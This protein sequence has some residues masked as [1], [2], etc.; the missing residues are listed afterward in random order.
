MGTSL[1]ETFYYWGNRTIVYH[2]LCEGLKNIF[3]AHQN[4]FPQHSLRAMEGLIYDIYMLYDIM[5]FHVNH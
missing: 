2:L 1:A 4:Y 5:F 3:R